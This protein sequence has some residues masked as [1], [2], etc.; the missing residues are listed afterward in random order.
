MLPRDLKSEDFRSYPP[1]ARQLA[2][3]HLDLLRQL[4]ITFVP[5]LLREIIDY[6][7]RFPAEQH[8]IDDEI[9][10]LSSLS[11]AQRTE[12]FQGFSKIS[13]S[14]KLQEFNWAM[15]PGTFLEQLSAYLWS[16]RQLDAFR[17]AATEYGNHLQSSVKETP[18]PVAR[19][20]I[21]IIGQGV[22]HYDAPLFQNLREHG[23]YFSQVS[24]DKGLGFLLD[25]AADRAK[26]FPAPY[27]HWYIDGGP[28]A[29]HSS[30]LTRVSYKELEPTRTALLR[31]IQSEIHRPGAGPEELRSHLSA[32]SPSELG[33]DP[34]EDM[35]LNSFKLKLFTEGSGTQIFSTTF[36]QWASREALRRA[37]PLTLVARFSPRQR[38]M[39][40]NELLS[41]N[42]GSVLDEVGSLVDAD[43]GAYY[44]WINQQ[45]LSGSERS[46]FL[47]W[48]EGHNE[49]L[50]I[51]PGL[52]RSTTSN[53]PIDL[54]H[55]LSLFVS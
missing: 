36:V 34:S 50:A 3:A 51:G 39:P 26:R 8:A 45:R 6:D 41:P 15:H 22:S 23:T 48:F 11:P 37:Q 55:V 47:V 24:S 40:M 19:L 28:P 16:T 18:L 43:M 27:G 31:N 52:P 33:M 17:K 5:S 4:P 1:K 14:E 9:N 42:N 2:I 10:T 38:Q 20:G 12:W 32:L 13:L 49:A 30:M 46:G 44:N 25:E 7:L 29:A 54:K 53:S 21:A 35:V